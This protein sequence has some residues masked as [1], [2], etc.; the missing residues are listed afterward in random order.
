MIQEVRWDLQRSQTPSPLTTTGEMN[1]FYYW[2]WQNI[3]TSFPRRPTREKKKKNK[4]VICVWIFWAW[5]FKEWKAQA[6]S[7][8]F[9]P[10][11]CLCSIQS[12]QKQINRWKA[13]LV[14]LPLPGTNHICSPKF[15]SVACKE[16]LSRPQGIWSSRHKKAVK[17]L[18]LREV[19]ILN[20][21]M[22]K[23][24]KHRGH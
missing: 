9:S 11:L 4:R 2:K 8:I 16:K 18:V 15:E 23:H 13:S 10:F 24:S 21:A 3:Q 20:L 12:C 17:K 1:F 7:G 5:S 14:S 6:E 22:I 19:T